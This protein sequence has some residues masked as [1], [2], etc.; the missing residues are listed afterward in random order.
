MLRAAAT[1][2]LVTA[3]LCVVGCGS[4]GP[5]ATNQSSAPITAEQALAY[6]HAVNLRPAD[7]PQMTGKGYTEVVRYL[8]E[9]AVFFRCVG[10]PAGEIKMKIQ[11][12]TLNSA[13]WWMRSTV[14]VAARPAFASAYVAALESSHGRQCFLPLDPD[15]KVK[16]ST[17]PI[18]AP[19]IGIRVTHN[20]GSPLQ[21]H[22]DLFA[23]AVGRAVVTL[24]VEGSVTPTLTAIEH[25]LAL[26]HSR[27]EANK[28]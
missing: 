13:Y 12:P 20:S 11:S 28:L 25:P 14:W 7:E 3:V 4:D 16:F 17:L 24:V 21:T 5:T 18:A 10:L 19:F 26:L 1:T 23:F 9:S 27:A 6:A 15:P 2:L 8:P 22:D